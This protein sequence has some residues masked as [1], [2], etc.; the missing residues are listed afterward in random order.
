MSSTEPPAKRQRTDG[1]SDAEIIR[2]TDFWLDDGTIILQVEATQFRVN[3]SVLGRHSTVFHDMFTMPLPPDEP[4]VEGCPVVVLSGDSV[5]D[6]CDLLGLMYPKTILGTP[7]MKVVLAVL[8]LGKKYDMQAFYQDCLRRLRAL[9]PDTLEAWKAQLETPDKH[10]TDIPGF[11]LP[12]A[13]VLRN[14]GLFSLLPA[15]YYKLLTD[16]QAADRQLQSL[17]EPTTQN[18]SELLIQ[19]VVARGHLSLLDLQRSNNFTWLYSTFLSP[20]GWATGCTTNAVCRRAVDSAREL[21]EDYGTPLYALEPWDAEWEEVE[22]DDADSGDE[23]TRLCSHCV[24]RAKATFEA[25]RGRCW[26]R[27]PSVF[28]LP[29]WDEL[30]KLDLE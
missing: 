15:L 18:P 1:D 2:S 4:L 3:K 22:N 9:F 6:W 10:I 13:V 27:L 11:Y 28:G 8:R 12:C 30:K 25:G 16:G 17:L 7:S 26:E 19:A 29:V 14:L 23:V 21:V 24:A 5:E 20:P